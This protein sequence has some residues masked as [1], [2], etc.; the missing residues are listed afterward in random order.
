MTQFL[1]AQRTKLL[2]EYSSLLHEAICRG[3]HLPRSA[4]LLNQEAKALRVS[5][6]SERI[7]QLESVLDSFDGF[8]EED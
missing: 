1:G 2:Q 8:G 3:I 7:R 5:E 6:L 4:F